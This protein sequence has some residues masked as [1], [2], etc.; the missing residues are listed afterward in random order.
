[1]QASAKENSRWPGCE[2]SIQTMKMAA[3]TPMP[4]NTQRCQ[5]PALARKLNAAPVLWARTT[6]KKL[7]MYV[8]SPSL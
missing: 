3:A 6:L 5:P 2:R 7:V 8:A 4:V 1:M